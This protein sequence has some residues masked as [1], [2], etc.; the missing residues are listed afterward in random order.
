[1]ASPLLSLPK[2]IHNALK[3]VMLDATLTRDGA[4]SGEPYDPATATPTVYTCKAIAEYCKG[5]SGNDMAGT[6][7]MKFTI[8]ANSLAVDPE[9]GDRLAIAVQGISGVIGNDESAVKS[10]PSRSVWECL[11]VT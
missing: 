6:S 1:M 4:N 7:D 11:V 8:L 3:G 10:D 2:Q 9:P 5:T